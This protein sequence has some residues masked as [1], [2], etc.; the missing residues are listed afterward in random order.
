MVRVSAG[1][2]RDEPHVVVPR[3]RPLEALLDRDLGLEA[4]QLARLGRVGNPVP[5]V[6]IVARQALVRDERR[7]QRLRDPELLLHRA[8]EL[9][10]RD[11]A[12][13]RRC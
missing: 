2:R 5:D 8:G 7:A 12:R 3:D 10:D 1:C 11:A 4:E 13:C 6:L 9:E